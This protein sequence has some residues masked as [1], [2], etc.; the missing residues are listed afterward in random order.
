MGKAE[1]WAEQAKYDLET[2]RAMSKSGRYLYVL[3]CCQ[4][5]AEKMLKA[6]VVRRKETFPPRTH[7]LARLAEEADLECEEET[8]GFLR[9]LTASYVQSRY[10]EDIAAAG[11][12]VTPR[13]AA[14]TL[15]RTEGLL[16]WLSS[17]LKS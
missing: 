6:L 10:P 9:Q 3:F 16:E 14:E 2:A 8:L 13:Q 5:A 4:Q 15:A 7:N 12:E 17:I 11:G 1:Q